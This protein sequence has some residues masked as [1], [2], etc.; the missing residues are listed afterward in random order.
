[1]F[2]DFVREILR[3]KFCEPFR[4]SVSS[5]L[6][7][8]RDFEIFQQMKFKYNYLNDSC[9]KEP[10]IV[11]RD[12]C[13]LSCR[14]EVAIHLHNRQK[15]ALHLIIIRGV[16]SQLNTFDFQRSFLYGRLE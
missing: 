15:G 9:Q 6:K 5:N 8:S 1:M 7:I 16:S 4:V 3:E 10:S 14:F 2:L 11:D 12:P 13:S